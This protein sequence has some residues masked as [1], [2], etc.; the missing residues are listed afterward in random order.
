MQNVKRTAF[1]SLQLSTWT[2]PVFCK[3]QLAA[4]NNQTSSYLVSNNCPRKRY[5]EG[6]A[7]PKK[8]KKL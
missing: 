5:M 1:V 4:Q 6:A 2:R 7:L 3:I 8:N